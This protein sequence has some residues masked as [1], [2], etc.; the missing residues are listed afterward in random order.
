VSDAYALVAGIFQVNDG[1][2]KRYVDAALARYRVEL[3]A[4]VD[5]AI[6]VAFADDAPGEE[7]I[8]DTW[9]L[10]VPDA[11]MPRVRQL[12]H[13]AG[14]PEATSTRKGSVWKFPDESYQA[15]RKAVGLPHRNPKRKK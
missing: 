2:A 9:S 14:Q 10:V 3:E 15:V 4:E 7:V 13:E 6:R 8:D 12:I 1:T 5:A 11:L